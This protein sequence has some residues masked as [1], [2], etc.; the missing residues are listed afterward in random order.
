MHNEGLALS[1]TQPIENHSDT[2]FW[3]TEFR[4]ERTQEDA[5]SIFSLKKLRKREQKKIL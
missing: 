1:Q 4:R 2:F 3:L 5:K